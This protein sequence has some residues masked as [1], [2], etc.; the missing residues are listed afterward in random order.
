MPRTSDYALL[1]ADAYRDARLRVDNYAPLPPE[2]VELTQYAESGSGDAATFGA[3]GFSARVYR[4]GSEIVISYAGTQFGGSA[5]GQFGDWAAGNGPLAVGLGS[6]Q[7]VQAALLYQ[8]VLSKEG[9]NITFTGHS[10]G[11]GLAA[12]MAVYFD[13]PAK[14]FA[15][16]PFASSVSAEQYVAG[17]L[18]PLAQIRVALFANGLIPQ[19]L[20]DYSPATD[21]VARSGNVQ[22]WAVQGE[23]L[24]AT[25]PYLNFGFIEDPGFR[26]HLL[27]AAE[28][29][30]GMTARHSIDLHAAALL[31]ASFNE[32]ASKLTT[33]LPRIFDDKL[34][35]ANL[36]SSRDQDFLVKLVRNEIGITGTAPNAM[37]SHFA[38]DLQKL[39]TNL[40][41]LNEAAQ[42]A[43]LAQGIEW[44]YWQGTDYAG[45]ESFTR[46]GA[47]LQYGT[48]QGSSLPGAENRAATYVSEWL[49]A[50]YTAST[51][52]TRFAPMGTVFAQWN[53]ATDA[54]AGVVATA[55]EQDKT[56]MFIG[57]GGNDAFNGGHRTDVMLAGGGD[58][59]LSGGAGNDLLYAGSGDDSLNGGTGADWLDGGS[60]K[61][62]YTFQTN[63]GR[64]TILD[65]DGQGSIVINGVTLT[66]GKKLAESDNVWWDATEAFRI[67]Q[68]TDTQLLITPKAGGDSITVKSWKP[69]DLGLV[70]GEEA[71]EQAEPAPPTL[72]FGDQRAPRLGIEIRKEDID[73]S[74]PAYGFY[75]W[76][77][78][79]WQPTGALLGGIAEIDFAD[80]ISAAYQSGEVKMFGFG[81]NDALTGG[82]GADYLDG[83]AGDDLISGGAGKDYILGGAGVDLIYSAQ[84]LY[85]SQRFESDD[86]YTPPEGTVPYLFAGPTWGS[87]WRSPFQHWTIDTYGSLAS[88]TADDYVD[89]GDENDWVVAGDGTDTVM[90][91]QG[92]DTVYGG[93]GGDLI[94]GESGND[95]LNGDGIT[96]YGYYNY[97]PEWQ[98]GSDIIEGGA[99]NDNI[100]GMGGSDYLLGGDD[101]DTLSGDGNADRYLS[102]TY[103]GNDVLLGEGGKD[104]LYGGG[105]NDLLFGGD[106][107][108]ALYGD[109]VSDQQGAYAVDV[110]FHGN[111][112]LYGGE[113]N[114]ELVGG[115]GN[116]TLSGNEG[117]DF[118]YGDGEALNAKHHGNDFLFGGEGNDLLRGEGGDDTL[119]AG[120]GLNW[121][122]G[123]AGDDTYVVRTADVTSPETGDLTNSTY[124]EDQEGRNTIKL[125]ATRES[126]EVLANES[127][128]VLR[129]AG[130][131][132]GTEAIVSIGPVL[133]TGT[134]MLEFAGGERVAL[135]R[136]MGDLLE[137]ETT[138]TTYSSGVAVV[139]AAQRDVLTL[140]GDDS[141]VMGGK[142]DDAIGLN[143]FNNTLHFDRGDGHDVL[144][145]SGSEGVIEFGTG[146]QLNDV[147]ATVNPGG[148]LTLKVVDEAGQLND[149][150]TVGSLGTELGRSRFITSLRFADGTQTSLTEFLRRGV[151]IT[152][153]TQASVVHGTDFADRFT[154]MPNGAE[155]LGGRGDDVYSFATGSSTPSSF[156]VN[157]RQGRDQ[158]DLAGVARW[159][160]VSLT[161]DSVSPNDLLIAAGGTTIRI[162]NALVL[163]NQFSLSIGSG[164]SI[165]AKSLASLIPA[166]SALNVQGTS[167]DD[168]IVT[169]NQSSFAAGNAGDDWLEGGTA[170]DLL[171]GGSGNDTLVG[172]GGGDVLLGGSG[173]DVYRVD[174]SLGEDQ[175]I[176]TEGN[177]TVR[178]MGAVSPA[179]L[180]VERLID[181]TDLRF[182]VSPQQTLTVR[183]ALEGAVERYEF[184]D[185]TVWT[186][187]QLVN[188]V[189]SPDGLVF[190]G[191]D[192][193]NT[194]HGT[195]GGDFMT[196]RM[197]NDVLIGYAG[198]DEIL[199]GDDNDTI[200]GD[201]GDDIL[202]GGAGNDLYLCNLGDGVDRLVDL[203]GA[204]RLRFG[205][206]ILPL[207]LVATR[208]VVEGVD[209]VRLSYSTNDAILIRDG[210]AFDD[211]SFEFANG[212]R[213]NAAA[214]FA[215]VM[216]GTSAVVVGTAQD[217]ELFGYASADSLMGLGGADTLKGGAGDDTLDGGAGADLLIGGKGVDSYVMA[218]GTG[219][220]RVEELSGE[221]SRLVL[222]GIDLADLKYTRIGGDLAVVHTASNT[223]SF[224]AGA[225]T[226][227]NRW[228]LIDTQ[229]G[230]HDLLTLASAANFTQTTAQ[231]KEAFARAVDA[232]AGPGV[233]F[234][235][236]MSEPG[237]VS[238]GVGTMNEQV[239][240]FAKTTRLIE[241]DSETV[242][243]NESAYSESKSSEYLYSVSGSR[244]YVH[245][246]VSY[247]Y[248]NVLISPGRRYQLPQG[249]GVNQLPGGSYLDW[250]DGDGDGFDD[251]GVVY[252][253]EPAKY[254]RYATSSYTQTLVTD[255]YKDTYYRTTYR[256]LRVI[257]EY[258]GG[259]SA[260]RVM[261][262]GTA[263]TLVSAGGGDDVIERGDEQWHDDDDWG[264][265]AGAADWIDGGAG[266]DRV[267]AGLGSDEVS[268][269]Q[270]SD[271]VDAGAGGDTYVVESTEDG[272]DVVYDHAAATIY[273][274]VSMQDFDRND[275]Q[276]EADLRAL[277][278]SPTEEQEDALRWRG[279][280]HFYLPITAEKLNLLMAMDQ[281]R[282]PKVGDDEERSDELFYLQTPIYSQGLDALI[283][284]VTG[285]PL[286]AYTYR[287]FGVEVRRP[288]VQFQEVQFTPSVVDT[289]R[290]GVG[291]ESV[292]LEM[293]WTIVAT[294]DGHK[295]ALSIGWGGAGGVH[296][297]MPDADSLPGV[298]I[299]RFEFADGTAW[300]LQQ[301]LDAAPPRPSFAL[302]ISVNARIGQIEV[303]EDEAWS[304]QIPASAFA[305][306]GD[307]MPRFELRDPDGSE[308]PSWLGFDPLTGTLSGS[309]TNGDVGERRVQITAILT[310]TQR[311]TQTVTLKITNT[312]DAPE[313]LNTFSDLS[314][315][316]GQV[317]DWKLSANDVHDQDAEDR[318][319]YS[320]QRADAPDLPDWLTFDHNTGR[321]Q[322]QPASSDVGPVSL[323]L[324]VQDT[325]GATVQRLFTLNVDDAP[326]QNLLGTELADVLSAGL[327]ASSL[328]GFAGDDELTGSTATDTLMGGAGNDTLSGLAG[329][330]TYVFTPGSGGFGND[331]VNDSPEVKGVLNTIRF[332][333][334]VSPADAIVTRARGN[335][336][337]RFTSGDSLVIGN[338]FYGVSESF[339]AISF[340]GGQQLTAEQIRAM[341]NLAPVM[342]VAPGDEALL[343]GQAISITLDPATFSDPDTSIG[344]T[345]TYSATLSD[346]SALPAWLT[347]NAATLT[348]ASL[349]G[350]STVGMLALRVL[351]TDAAGLTAEALFNLDVQ[352][353]NTAPLLNAPLAAQLA[354]A[355]IALSYMIPGD[356]FTD[357]DAGDVLTL[358]VTMADGSPLPDW[359]SFDATT[360]TLS[361]TPPLAAR[362]SLQLKVTAVDVAGASAQTT[363]LLDV[364]N[365]IEGTD[366]AQT[367][368][369]TSFRDLINGYGGS[370]TLNGGAGA[371]VM[372]G[373]LGNDTYVLDQTGDQV[374]ELAG[375]GTDTVQSAVSF[376][377]GDNVE[378]LTLTGAAANSAT[379]NSLNNS[380]TGNAAANTLVGAEG[381]DSLNGG[382]G[383]DT[384]IGGLGND[385]YTVDQAGDAV[386]EL[387]GEGTDTVRASFNYTLGEQLENLTLTGN[388]AINGTGNGLKNVLTGNAAANVL[389][390]GA[391]NDTLN[392]GA[393]ADTLQGE[394]DDDTYVVDNAGDTVVEMADEGNDLVQSGISYALTANVERLTLTGNAAVDGTGNDLGNTLA[395]NAASNVLIGGAGNDILN[396]GAGADTLRGGLGNDA[397]TID[398]AG[399]V[400]EELANDGLDTVA[401]SVS[402]TLANHVENLTLSG[403]S[404]LSATGNALDNVLT[405]NSGANALLGGAGN[406]TLNGGAGADTMAGGE[407]GDTYVVDNAGDVITELANEGADTVLASRTYT[408][409]SNLE[410]LTLTGTSAINGI[411]NALNNLLIGNGGNNVLTGA[412]G[413]DTL[414]GLAGN[415]TLAGGTGNDTY[416]LGLGYGAETVQ[417]NDATSGNTDLLRIL[418]GVATDQLWFRRVSNNLEVSIIGTGDRA[419]IGN[420]YTGNQY[421]VEQFQTSDNQMLL[422]SQVD[423][424]VQAM[425]AFS[426]PPPGQ[427]TLTPA[428]QSALSPVIAA[429]WN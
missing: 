198:N 172:H 251:D 314:V 259:D 120:N 51:G 389:L 318:H 240:Q 109:D 205:Q 285:S 355:N 337:L 6:P 91:G 302:Q 356:T 377:L 142:G 43:L 21:Y 320:V 34:Y 24:E 41:G 145:G 309:P 392:G 77:A 94:F 182:S 424:L 66:S 80:V 113:G 413:D 422:N 336:I 108:D 121:L 151:E 307:R 70:L 88:D 249:S 175:I 104:R 71:E 73:A 128:I 3:F 305:I 224:L 409:G 10:L 52:D 331:I 407:G 140:N 157:D 380:L 200:V 294:D 311:A 163:A 181:S 227:G 384:L 96:F 231:R 346:G 124:I 426:P 253:V 284:R 236:V 358:S 153:D 325:S 45:Q 30:L 28:T 233:V 58:D 141:T 275:T 421:K 162:V 85:A 105:G 50:A 267:Y 344:E 62:T 95:Y 143:G 340:A 383:A 184:G 7:A 55:R 32:W 201:L 39:G 79:T 100:S 180:L 243:L 273:V 397:Y 386:I 15:P 425:A 68:V 177:N 306:S 178:F 46:A 190:S 218:A 304:F 375:E 270:G 221:A 428:Q 167:D 215:E 114:D 9:N 67:A 23:V 206:G 378:N 342:S 147:Q 286:I 16:A 212:S 398:N 394:A 248:D 368:T 81:G 329:R 265:V 316:A 328:H 222:S 86:A 427:T 60:G 326:I 107:D 295:Q 36:V 351:A 324:S 72:Y 118:L 87:Y 232:Q 400:I 14:V 5:T 57:Q 260:N 20:A 119:D 25:L 152:A 315:T 297:V 252:V 419:T 372:T 404:A 189:V 230:E 274:Q 139:G 301:M 111:D 63:H 272:W 160:D 353:A 256:G 418:E 102:G 134:F 374:I 225:F 93:G 164:A 211:Q 263:S 255:Y 321:L 126:I 127:S 192:I 266:N 271:Y 8:E 234:G 37:L 405:G 330:D 322:G 110:T 165:Q 26:T 359:L 414:Q 343:Q 347:F 159:E 250:V 429:N 29:E 74:H 244:T 169:S 300:S 42:N 115:S 287:G 411:G 204:E 156:R 19:S 365:R 247:S 161:R 298:G 254:A 257:E 33:A 76:S 393:G 390:G 382:A 333:A 65:S 396:G 75:D 408:L 123:D 245:N 339:T 155:L 349:K 69:G 12:M 334:G 223:I 179:T 199:G 406:D 18:G 366:A 208:E 403:S 209:Y 196:G 362:G 35:Q 242:W 176:D 132:P 281:R 59:A 290:F 361:G 291:V 293:G 345:L 129:W 220:D 148:T 360:R 363:L 402:Y 237:S 423:N 288:L 399:D 269:G 92:N 40:T 38:A 370:D 130:V 391:G 135:G 277:I 117:N 99:G 317:F 174:L 332:E 412:A 146:I 101:D 376:S 48:A 280:I 364:G 299:E 327:L 357:A 207:S 197:G 276:I 82:S 27:N 268:G 319:S 193:D 2:W 122:F 313:V 44:Y 219:A 348:F 187:H 47:L 350:T 381:N 367:L 17:I 158:I 170:A 395:G 228:T 103:N 235:K 202:N 246:H 61:D 133:G 54:T 53:V 264:A 188:Q 90:G 131:E 323:R 171:N 83:G 194:V 261:L 11:G 89:A 238:T 137:A 229:G 282:P 226:A 262:E 144:S 168:H 210:V 352:S 136:L 22:A 191:D 417:E 303:F 186:L 239:F 279:T 98:H 420:W 116:D 410:N 203:E 97:T 56:Q 150:I 84:T 216:V 401:S 371:D 31:S 183:R 385:T 112:E 310:D 369:G 125:D 149:Q 387:A 415:D 195:S 379:G 213:W 416:L 289:V 1:A 312:N 341:V 292:N 4:N 258:V 308:L 13:R 78:V 241:D 335:L 166:M 354:V 338:W 64:D 106:Q 296:V 217:D 278:G 214:L 185:G 373:G 173:S 283:A 138:Q 388:A 49:N 154:A